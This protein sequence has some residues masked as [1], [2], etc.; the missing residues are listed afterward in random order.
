MVK[1]QLAYI[2]YIDIL[3]HFVSLITMNNQ[4]RE[5]ILEVKNLPCVAC[6][7]PPISQAH[8]ICQGGRRLGHYYVLSLCYSCHEG[9]FSIGN[10]KKSFVAKYGT[11]LELLEKVYEMLGKPMPELKSK[12]YKK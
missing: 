9:K 1:L 8:H 11:E 10:A 12:V 6:G 3:R 4:E 5:H 7:K 2:N